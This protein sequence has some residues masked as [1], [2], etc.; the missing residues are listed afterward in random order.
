MLEEILL[1]SFHEDVLRGVEEAKDDVRMPMLS[2][3]K[4]IEDGTFVLG[5]SLAVHLILL[6]FKRRTFVI[7]SGLSKNVGGDSENGKPITVA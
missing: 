7:D 6:V 5:R 1:S 4:D 2:F 3:H